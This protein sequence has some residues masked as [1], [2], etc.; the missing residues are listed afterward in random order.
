MQDVMLMAPPVS[1]YSPNQDH[2]RQHREEIDHLEVL[3]GNGARQSRGKDLGD[4]KQDLIDDGVGGKSSPE[5]LAQ[6]CI[7][8][9]VNL[10]NTMAR[11][12]NQGGHDQS[13]HE[14][15]QAQTLDGLGRQLIY[16]GEKTTT[17]GHGQALDPHPIYT[18]ERC[19]L[20]RVLSR[21][22]RGDQTRY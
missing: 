22:Q 10:Y 19:I 20:Y 16:E 12:S 7:W 3:L 13:N 4:H 17:E 21:E 15:G 9:T 8:E 18:S 1:L 5:G 2:G 11:H 6:K 14:P